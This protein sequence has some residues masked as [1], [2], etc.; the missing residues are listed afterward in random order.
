MEDVMAN[1]S[2]DIPLSSATT[3]DLTNDDIIKL[4]QLAEEKND[5]KSAF[6]LYQ[7]YNFSMHDTNKKIFY[8]ELAAEN[9]HIIAKNNLSYIY[10]EQNNLDKA[11]EWA[12]KANQ[13][14]NDYAERI[15]KEI[16]KRRKE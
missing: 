10:L 1:S 14:G 8:L 6:R 9:G 11:Y 5:A 12:L 15:L 16:A 7:Y 3:Y 13:A 4:S 2:D